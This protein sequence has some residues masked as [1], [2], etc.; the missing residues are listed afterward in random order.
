MST[1]QQPAIDVTGTTALVT[2]GTS[3]LG[4]AMVR[5]LAAAGARVAFTSRDVDRARRAPGRTLCRG[6]WPPTWPP[7]PCGSTSWSR[8]R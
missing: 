3:G 7:A 2:G 4:L 6:S 1:G 8:A 5:A